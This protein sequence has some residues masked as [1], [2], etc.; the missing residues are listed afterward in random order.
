MGANGNKKTTK[1]FAKEVVEKTN[2]EYSL[3]GEYLYSTI[4]T[5]IRHNICGK[6]FK[7]KPVNFI[8]KDK[9][10]R[11]PYCSTATNKRKTTEQFKEEVKSISND[12]VVLGEYKSNKEKIK[13]RHL[14]CH[15]EFEIKPNHFL[16]RKR[17]P[18][19]SRENVYLNPY[20]KKTEDNFKKEMLFTVG[21]EYILIGNYVNSHTKVSLLHKNCNR[22]WEVAP[23]TFL[24]GTRC[25]HCIVNHSKME[26]IL[27]E[28]INKNFSQYSTKKLRKKDRVNNRMY[29]IDIFIPE[30]N[31]GFEYNGIYWH[32]TAKK[33]NNYHKKK[34][35]FFLSQGIKIYFLWEH[36]GEDICKNIIEHIL[37]NDSQI[38]EYPYIEKGTK[39][40]YAN[41]DLYPDKPP[42]I[43]GYKFIN[44]IDRKKTIKISNNHIFDIYNSGYWKYIKQ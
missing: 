41:K 23:S 7:V 27:L 6:V 34:Q 5:T 19:C 17:C 30:L 31:I 25:P 29:E 26:D 44:K 21:D 40:L 28:Y 13:I 24:Y 1:S 11:C 22:I 18:I 37:T 42:Y 35:G 36:W 33:Q 32:S 15:R 14:K 8:R 9:G 20:N 38:E 43:Q 3:D 16:V 39:Y 10:I 4:E 2:G 12:F